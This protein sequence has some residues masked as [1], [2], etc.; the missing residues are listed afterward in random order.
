M[1]W[2]GGKR[3]HAP[4]INERI[5]TVDVYVEPFAGSLAVLLQRKP[6]RREVV[7]DTDS[8]IVN[9]WR[10]VT[11]YPDE[12]AHWADWPTFHDDLTA[13]HRWLVRWIGENGER[14]RSDPDYCDAK[15]AGWWCWGLSLWIGGGWCQAAYD[16]RPQI[17]K[18]IAG[19]GVNA[20][21]ASVP[22]QIPSVMKNIT[23]CG[24]S[25]QRENMP[26][27]QIPHVK[28]RLGGSG[29][30]TQRE[31]LPHDK[32]PDISGAR[33]G[34]KG[35]SIHRERLPHD[36]RPSIHGEGG[37]RGICAQRETIDA[38]ATLEWLRAIAARFKR[39]IVLNRSWESAVTTS[40]L[41][42]TATS[43]DYSVGIMMDPPY[44]QD[45]RHADL[46]GS[47]AVRSSNETAAASYEWAVKHGN[48]YRIAYCG[49]E[50]DF[51]VPDGWDYTL[52]TFKGIRDAERRE[53]RD[54][55]MYS[56]AC[57]TVQPSLFD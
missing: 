44:I 50:G 38:P 9:F 43:G 53:R 56:P 12:V 1:T 13:R 3:R 36:K 20:Q 54:I 55:V 11:Q 23:G 51:P 31:K 52:K 41:A 14:L 39:V 24:V 27:A 2:Y 30:S 29:V 49:H 17:G 28:N 35:I 8:G 42:Q 4:E 18:T 21:R 15:A 5:G 32:R 10:A 57:V 47:D 25:A 40:V 48:R 22:G 46:Y 26:S 45:D 33:M 16:Q 7:C 19:Q 34:G 6:A 37:G